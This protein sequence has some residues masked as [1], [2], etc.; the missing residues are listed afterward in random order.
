[1]AMKSDYI[2]GTPT[3][4]NLRK[5]A[6][7]CSENSQVNATKDNQE[8]TRV[9]YVDENRVRH[10]DGS[11][12]PAGWNKSKDGVGGHR[13]PSL[14]SGAGSGE[15]RAALAKVQSRKRGA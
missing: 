10:L 3:E 14:G 7:R 1:M 2:S 6:S 8:P 9:G 11:T 4:A 13:F 12:N 15:G 5:W